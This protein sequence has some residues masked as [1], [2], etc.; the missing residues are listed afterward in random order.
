M[1]PKEVGRLAVCLPDIVNTGFAGDFTPDVVYE[2]DPVYNPPTKLS[3]Y[4]VYLNGKH[5][6]YIPKVIFDN[7]FRWLDEEI[8]N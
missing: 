5:I 1:Q 7:N 4:H 3:G 8:N 2:V 6:S